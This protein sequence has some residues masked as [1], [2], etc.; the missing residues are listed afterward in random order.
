[1]PQNN[2]KKVPSA[3]DRVASLPVVLSAC[4]TLSV[5]YK[6]T[7]DRNP[8]LKSLCEGLERRMASLTTAVYS[9]VSPVIVKLEPKI[10]AANYVACKGLDWLETSFP[11]LQ[12]PTDEVVAAAK[13]KMGDLQGVVSDAASGAAECVQHTVSW[14]VSRIPQVEDDDGTN[15]SL[16]QR[17]IRVTTLG[18]D[19]AL[20]LS[21]TLIDD[22]FPPTEEDREKAHLEGSKAAA[23]SRNYPVRLIRL[24]TKLCQRSYHAVC[25]KIQFVQV[26][27][28]LSRSTGVVQDLQKNCQTLV[29]SLR[30]LPQYLQHQTVAVLLFFTQMYS[31]GH[32]T[33]KPERFQGRTGLRVVG[34][35]P[36]REPGRLQSALRTRPTKTHAFENGYNVKECVQ[37]YNR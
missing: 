30:G 33:S 11:V 35:S 1:M 17:A 20:T 21:E 18:L 27:E 5:L 32:Q 4:S 22:V 16:V 23:P 29:W 19:S 6:D 7:K 2:N 12:S 3:I 9:R 24:T 31:L 15:Q 10:S 37:S 14:V 36:S 13:N 34:A 28:T 26:R 8:S 25:L